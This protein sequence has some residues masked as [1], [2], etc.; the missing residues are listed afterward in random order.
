MNV[1]WL[2]KRNINA[3]NSSAC[4]TIISAGNDADAQIAFRGA[5]RD[6]MMMPPKPLDRKFDDTGAICVA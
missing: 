6:R 4:C 1:N 5:D 3:V 2:M